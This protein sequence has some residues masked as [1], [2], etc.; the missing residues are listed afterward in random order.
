MIFGDVEMAENIDF[1]M[2]CRT[3]YRTQNW[4]LGVGTTDAPFPAIEHLF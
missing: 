3:R 4:G 2:F 1:S